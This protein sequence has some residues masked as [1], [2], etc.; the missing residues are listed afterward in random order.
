M[1]KTNSPGFHSIQIW[2]EHKV[3][4]SSI[5]TRETSTLQLKIMAMVR[6][7]AM[8]ATAMVRMERCR[9]LH[10]GL[11]G[12]ELLDLGHVSLPTVPST[13]PMVYY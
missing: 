7:T 9:H 4:V 1:D 8:E 5:N 12:L 2:A 10:V 3:K 13:C 11:Q 6:A